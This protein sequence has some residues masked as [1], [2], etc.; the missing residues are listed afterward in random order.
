MVFP[1][2]SFTFFWNSSCFLQALPVGSSSLSPSLPFSSPITERSNSSSVIVPSGFWVILAALFVSFNLTTFLLQALSSSVSFNHLFVPALLFGS[3]LPLYSPISGISPLALSFSSLLILLSS[4]LFLS[5]ISLI[6]RSELCW[7]S[8]ISAY[9]TCWALT[10]VHVSIECCFPSL[11]ASLS[12]SNC[13][14]SYNHCTNWF[15]LSLPSFF[16]HD[17]LPV[18]FF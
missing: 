5:S 12:S 9:L 7:F 1:P 8:I 10:S 11:T 3:S 13:S 18:S 2:L 6:C 15:G 14:R 4:L 17:E 16:S